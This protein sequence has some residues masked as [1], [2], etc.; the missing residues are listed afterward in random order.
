MQP[1]SCS[2]LGGFRLERQ[3]SNILTR[4]KAFCIG[5]GY[6]FHACLSSSSVL[7]SIKLGGDALTCCSHWTRPFLNQCFLSLPADHR[8]PV[9]TWWNVVQTDRIT[10]SSGPLQSLCCAATNSTI[11]EYPYTF[12][13]GIVE[14]SKEVSFWPW[15]ICRKV[16]KSGTAKFSSGHVSL[17]VTLSQGDGVHGE[18]IGI[19]C[20]CTTSLIIMAQM[21]CHTRPLIICAVGCGHTLK[22]GGIGVCVHG[23]EAPHV[24]GLWFC[25]GFINRLAMSR[26]HW[27]RSTDVIVLLSRAR[28]SRP[29]FVALEHVFIQSFNALKPIVVAAWAETKTIP[30][31]FERQRPASSDHAATMAL[32]M[33][34]VSLGHAA[35]ASL[36]SSKRRLQS[37]V[38]LPLQRRD[39]F[40]SN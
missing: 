30:H 11:H 18:A 8:S 24:F 9:D 1:D 38:E 32:S 31:V 34:W 10:N 39:K 37:N 5:R 14:P 21:G 20:A 6:I 36:A 28:C 2:D 40:T 27:I 13:V 7:T 4:C 33:L 26:W 12:C 19:T 22:D 17:Y 35:K 23:G 25:P 3:S 16:D 29:K 15:G